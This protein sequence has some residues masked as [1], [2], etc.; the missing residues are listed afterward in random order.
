MKNCCN[1]LCSWCGKLGNFPPLFFRLILAFGFFGPAMRKIN[2]FSNIIDWFESMNYIMP[3][4]MAYLA[5]GTEAIGVVLLFLGLFTRLIT[6][7]LMVVMV[8]AITTVHL[9][10][11]FE[12]GNNGIEIPLYYFLMLFSLFV[13]GAGSFSLDHYIGGKMSSCC[14]DK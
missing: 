5:T 10:N 3:T 13:T 9:G 12:A 8:V 7:P 1:A 2:N 11:G 6:L 4:L 14:K